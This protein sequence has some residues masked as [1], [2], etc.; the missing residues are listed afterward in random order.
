M[1]IVPSVLLIFDKLIINTTLG[2]KEGKR[3]WKK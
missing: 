2:F 3:A 1:F